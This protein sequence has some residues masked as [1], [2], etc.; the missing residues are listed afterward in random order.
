[1]AINQLESNLE[2]ITTTIAY[3]EKNNCDDEEM[4]N[5]LKKERN[6]LLKDLNLK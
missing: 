2:A 1:M 5:N 3:L 4:L 6:K